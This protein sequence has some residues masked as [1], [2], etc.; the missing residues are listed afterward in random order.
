MFGRNYSQLSGS[1]RSQDWG[2]KVMEIYFQTSSSSFTSKSWTLSLKLP[3]HYT[4]TSAIVNPIVLINVGWEL[5]TENQMP[6]NTKRCSTCQTTF[7]MGLP[8]FKCL[9]LR[10]A[11]FQLFVAAAN[12][13]Y[14][15]WIKLISELLFVVIGGK[16]CFCQDGNTRNRK[17]I[18]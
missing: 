13:H 2:S 10:W 12:H 8:L 17:W 14:R 5:K 11:K 16:Q 9:Q 6:S 7:R 15:Q 4:D 1:S 3:V 18:G